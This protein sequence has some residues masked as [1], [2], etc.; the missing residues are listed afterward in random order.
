MATQPGHLHRL[1]ALRDP[2]LR[3]PALVVETHHRLTYVDNRPAAG[4][5]CYY[6]RVVQVDRNIAWPSPVRVTYLA[7]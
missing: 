1:L 7:R 6:V 4:E 3:R 2:L 5:C